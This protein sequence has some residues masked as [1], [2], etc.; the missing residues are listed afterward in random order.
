M[1]LMGCCQALYCQAPRTGN[2]LPPLAR[3]AVGNS[4]GEKQHLS[5]LHSRVCHLYRFWRAVPQR[6][7]PL[8]R[9]P[10]RASVR[11]ESR[12]AR[13]RGQQGSRSPQPSHPRPLPPGPRAPSAEGPPAYLF[14]RTMYVV[15]SWS[16]CLFSCTT[17]SWSDS[18]GGEVVILVSQAWRRVGSTQASWAKEPHRRRRLGLGLFSAGGG[19][20]PAVSMLGVLSGRPRSLQA[21]AFGC[22][23]QR[24][25]SSHTEKSVQPRPRALCLEESQM[26]PPVSSQADGIRS[27]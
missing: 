10:E 18:F 26:L 4:L 5:L 23:A 19:E 16:S 22:P 21:Q 14:S 27:V 13:I 24:C 15:S 7:L 9:G 1:S 17:S 20:R 6:V 11:T 2:H 3:E 25:N 12:H 8:Y